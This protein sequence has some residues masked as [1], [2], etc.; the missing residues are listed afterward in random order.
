MNILLLQAW[1]EL[2]VMLRQRETI[3]FGLVLPVMFLAFVGIAYQAGA[4]KGYSSINYLLPPY[5]VMAI[6]SVA[7]VN[8]GISFATQRATGAL[9]RLGGTPLPKISLLLAKTLS[10]AAL[11]IV[12]CLLL[13]LVARYGYTTHLPG[14]KLAAVVAV[15]IGIASFSAI[16]V[17]LGGTIAADGAA[18]IT[19]AIY[20]PLLFLGGAFIPVGKMPGVLEKIAEALPPARLTD[21][22]TT[23]LVQNRSLLATG[24]DLWIVGGWGLAA[25]VLASIFLRWE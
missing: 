14:S 19:N 9:K 25:L 15:I 23:I 16:G 5:L 24:P 7:I 11:I 10:G 8:L 4:Y 1:I 21:A 6:M 3:F 12:A 17:A 13:T 22:L 18:A 2:R 20:L